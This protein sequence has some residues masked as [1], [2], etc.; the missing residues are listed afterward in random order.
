MNSKRRT[1]PLKIASRSAL[2]L[3]GAFTLSGCY[4]VQEHR[5]R[6]FSADY[7]ALPPTA[8]ARVQSATI[9][10]GDSPKAVYFA[11]G[12]P[13]YVR[14]TGDGEVEWIYWGLLLDDA[15][16]ATPQTLRFASRSE[17]RIPQAG[18][19]RT[20]LRLRFVDQELAEWT[21]GPIDL[22]ASGPHEPLRMGTFPRIP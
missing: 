8:Q 1:K 20:E 4:A 3:L 19:K 2:V 22:S 21:T 18:E 16:H 9:A 11:L 12:T 7:A 5:A 15:T 14:A 17:I 13:N 6:Q 10:P